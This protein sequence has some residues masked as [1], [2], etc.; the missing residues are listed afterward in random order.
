MLNVK[1]LLRHLYQRYRK[2][3]TCGSSVLVL[4]TMIWSESP[5]G[6]V[7]RALEKVAVE[8]PVQSAK[9]M[10]YQSDLKKAVCS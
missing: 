1:Q 4:E 8:P 9:T 6:G 7:S 3:S 5:G 2:K 10:A